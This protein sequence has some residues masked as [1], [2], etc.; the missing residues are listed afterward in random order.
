MEAML[1]TARHNFHKALL[2][3]G[4]LTLSSIKK[5]HLSAI[6]SNAD[7]GQKLSAMVANRIAEKLSENTGVPLQFVEKKKDGQ[8]LGNDFE[9]HCTNFLRETFLNLSHLRPGQWIIEKVSSRAEGI[10]GKYEQYSHLAELGKLAKENRELKSFLGDGYTIAP[11]V[12]IARLPEP[13]EVINT[14]LP[15]VDNSICQLA[16]LRLSNHADQMNPEQLIHASISCKFTMRSDRAQNTRTEALNLIRSR[17]GRS[18]H[19][20]SLTAE[21]TPTRIASLAMGTGDMD[22]V[23]HFALKELEEALIELDKEDSL[24]LLRAMIEGK[25]LRDISDLPLD[26]AV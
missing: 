7:S 10:L 26:L 1:S 9:E 25:R 22:C 16:K 11:D 3:N 12:V 4:T 15:I 18:P 23:Y 5:Y 20:V 13:D 2:Q 8:T 24:D 19:I 6:A 17:K 14:K 21:P